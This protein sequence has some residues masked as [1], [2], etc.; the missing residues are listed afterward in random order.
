MYH[1]Q[2]ILAPSLPDS[3]EWAMYEQAIYDH[4]YDDFDG[5]SA[6]YFWVAATS[7]FF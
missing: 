4:W 7:V 3:A 5:C 2:L 1:I 6:H